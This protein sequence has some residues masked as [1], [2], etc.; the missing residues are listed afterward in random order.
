[1][2]LPLASYS[3]VEKLFLESLHKSKQ[4]EIIELNKKKS[5]SDLEKTTSS[6]YPSLGIIGT[7]RY[8]N[9]LTVS[10]L[11]ENEVDTQV[12]LNLEQKL[13]QGGAEFT[14]SDYNKIIPKKADVQKEKEISQYYGEFS[15]LYFK[16]SSAVEEYSKVEALYNNLKKRVQI[17]KKRTAIGR[18][19]RAD[20]FALESQL[21]RLE[22]DL[23]TSKAQL[24][25]A[26]TNFINFSELQAVE[27]KI[28]SVNPLML[29]LQKN[30]DLD[31]RPDLQSLKLN[32]E[33]S[34]L[35][36]KIEESSYYPQVDLG[37]NY[38]VDKSSA[39]NNEWDVSLSVKLNLLDFGKRSSSVQSKK[40]VERIN[41]ARFKYNKLNAQRE[42]NN[43]IDNFNAKKDEYKS[44]KN[45]LERS[46]KSYDEQLKD[47]NRGLITQ[48]EVIRSLDDVISL[49]KLTIR[50][51]LEVKSLYYQANAYLGNYPRG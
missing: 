19:R 14:I 15:V 40:V 49:E 4:V 12:A 10:S 2:L 20:L 43:Y 42:W 45:A 35:D 32:V 1:M 13:F 37:A 6:L 34:K 23:N 44:L 33:S 9:N 47:L 28:D 11:D 50:S 17:V 16:L 22:A 29:N 51:A 31:K 27:A 26:K 39:G 5:L 18:D 25:T 3:S 30:E 48:I 36:T 46:K 21:F 38:Y 41:E 24:D 8:G 7:S